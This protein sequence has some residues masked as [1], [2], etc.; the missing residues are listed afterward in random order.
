[1]AFEECNRIHSLMSDFKRPW[2]IA[3]GWAIDLFVGRETRKHEDIE[4][5]ILREDQF[6]LRKYLKEWNVHKVEDNV[7]KPWG[8]EYLR[9]PIHEFHAEN[10]ITNEKLEVLINE[11]QKNKWIF[12]RDL[13]VTLPLFGVGSYTPIGIG[14]PY[15]NPEV[16]LLYK[17]KNPRV[18]DQQDF[19]SILDKLTIEQREWL[20]NA[21]YLQDKQHQWLKML[22]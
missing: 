20:H 17:A 10:K 3:G 22:G 9:S 7:L 11:S 1:M 5:A 18:K 15:L 13:R 8:K 19:L 6:H 4:I 14:I 16:V 21:I 2:F 12:R